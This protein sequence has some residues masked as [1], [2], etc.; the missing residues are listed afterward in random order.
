MKV[1]LVRPLVAEIAQLDASAAAGDPDF[2]EPSTT[3]KERPP[4]RLPAQLEVGTHE[5]LQQSLAGDVPD[6][7][8]VLVLDCEDLKQRGLVDPKTNAVLLRVGDRIVRV[9][10][11]AG[12]VV[13]AFP[14]PPG[15]FIVELR[16]T[17]GLDSDRN[18]LLAFCGDRAQGLTKGV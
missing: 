15:L 2:K 9:L 11:R 6:S 13:L 3:R 14:H 1:R 5:R 16:P 18:L 7:R 12:A 8:L 17:A 10:N 4:I